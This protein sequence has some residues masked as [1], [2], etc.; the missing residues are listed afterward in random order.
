MSRMRLSSVVVA[1]LAA[2]SSLTS[3]PGEPFVV[4]TLKVMPHL[5]DKA[6]NYATF[7]RLARQAAA[8]GASLILTPEGYLDGYAGNPR[9]TRPEQMP[10][11][12][13]PVDGPW[14]TRA[15]ALARELKVF[16]AFGFS[17]LRGDEVYNTIALFSP[18]GDLQGRYSKSHVVNNEH[19]TPGRELPVFETR[20]GRM[21][22]LICFDR[23]PPETARIL[24]LKGAQFI[25]VPAYG[26]KSTPIDEDI[27]MQARAQENGVYIVY[28]S[29]RNAFTVDPEGAIISKV[30]GDTDELMFARLTLDGRIGDTN[31]IRVRHPELYGRLVE[32]GGK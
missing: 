1:I 17:E 2:C 25:L 10:G 12:S 21:G 29:P 26:E 5:N 27:L 9:F 4:A 24:A 11:L 14:V 8:Q 22:I 6:A 18:E 19:Y 20:L 28:T 15:A 30:S 3:S 16:I 31:A 13:E 32:D 23:R 7:E